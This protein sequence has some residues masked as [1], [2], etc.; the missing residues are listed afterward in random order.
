MYLHMYKRTKTQRLYL[1]VLGFLKAYANFIFD[2]THH[3]LQTTYKI[4]RRTVKSG[5]SEFISDIPSNLLIED[6]PRT[7]EFTFIIRVN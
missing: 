2:L 3:G 5:N 4:Y 7:S 1:E 6:R